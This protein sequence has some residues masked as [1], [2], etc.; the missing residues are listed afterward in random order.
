[1]DSGFRAQRFRFRGPK[2]V[3]LSAWGGFGVF[4]IMLGANVIIGADFVSARNRIDAASARRV[5][6]PICWMRLSWG[7]HVH[8]KWGQDLEEQGSGF[9]GSA[10]SISGSQR[11][12]SP[13]MGRFRGV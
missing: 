10:V 3:T 5:R 11:C 13:R 7:P 2:G 6:W 12:N 4:E 1:M 9:S 8:M